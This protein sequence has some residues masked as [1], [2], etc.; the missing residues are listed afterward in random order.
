MCVLSFLH[1]DPWVQ[2]SCVSVFVYVQMCS[3]LLGLL[4]LV[5]FSYLPILSQIY[6]TLFPH[7]LEKLDVVMANKKWNL[8]DW[9]SEASDV[10][11]S[12]R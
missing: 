4:V 10:S 12:T 3:R 11:D 2:K 5:N 7:V 6:L 9:G 1:E 8:I